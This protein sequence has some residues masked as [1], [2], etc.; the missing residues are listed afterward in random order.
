MPPEEWRAAKVLGRGGRSG[1]FAPSRKGLLVRAA[2]QAGGTGGGGDI[3]N[4]GKGRWTE[5]TGAWA[6]TQESLRLCWE[7][8]P[9]KGGCPSK[10][11]GIQG[12]QAEKKTHKRRKT[13]SC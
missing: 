7:T 4:A 9:Q 8:G 10:M 2:P 11:T 5:G 6:S 12:H 3:R 13:L 1:T